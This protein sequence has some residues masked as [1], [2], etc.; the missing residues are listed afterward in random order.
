MRGG[1]THESR[2]TAQP[3]QASLRDRG[4]LSVFPL[5][6]RQKKKTR[7]R[8]SIPNSTLLQ[9]LF[10]DNTNDRSKSPRHL[11]EHGM[12]NLNRA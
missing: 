11:T 6:P 9:L 2:V 1:L 3:C 7:R 4:P 5:L 8:R 12:Y 10:Y